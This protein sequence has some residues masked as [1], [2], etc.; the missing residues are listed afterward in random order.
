MSTF[1]RSHGGLPKICS[2]ARFVAAIVLGASSLC[3]CWTPPRIPDRA[4][5]E[6]RVIAQGLR[7]VTTRTDRVVRAVDPARHTV[8]L[9]DPEDRT[10][11]TYD[12]EPT[13]GR[14][15]A[16]HLGQRVKVILIVRLTVYVGGEAQGAQAAPPISDVI[17]AK[18]AAVD[19]SYRLLTVQLRGGRRE[20]FKLP[21][22]AQVAAMQSG[23]DVAIHPEQVVTLGLHGSLLGV[24]ND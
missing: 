3:G 16:A 4:A 15:A 6:P 23:D 24:R 2:G 22:G 14:A 10:T 12:V 11:V 13:I 9:F 1:G 21:L 19:P 7:A 8:A 17:A 18:V 5:G 20:T